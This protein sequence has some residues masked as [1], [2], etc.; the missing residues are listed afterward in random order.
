MLVVA[1]LF[2][3]FRNIFFW[4]ITP[5]ALKMTDYGGATEESENAKKIKHEKIANKLKKYIFHFIWFSI[6]VPWNISLCSQQPWFSWLYT[7]GRYSQLFSETGYGMR[8]IK[9]ANGAHAVEAIDHDADPW[10][11]AYYLYACIQMAWYCHAFVEDTLWERTRGDYWMMV[12]HH[13]ITIS[14]LW[15]SLNGNIEYA[16]VLVL[17]PMD[18]MDLILYSGKIFHLLSNTL[19]GTPR[20]PFIAK[21]QTLAMCVIN[22]MWFITRIWSFN[23]IEISFIIAH[24]YM[25]NV[26]SVNSPGESMPFYVYYT[27]FLGF[28]L[29]ILQTIW[30]F[31]ISRMTVRLLKSGVLNETVF[32]TYGQKPAEVDRKRQ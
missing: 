22:L 8:L 29:I 27:L 12:L 17:L 32:N 15:V 24:V 6:M 20:G 3:C 14:L 30:G 4:L 21:L 23:V 7:T 28:L 26:F 11:Q 16:G 25:P 2:T 19:D 10:M 31:M 18:S 1:V 5:M 9:D 13:L